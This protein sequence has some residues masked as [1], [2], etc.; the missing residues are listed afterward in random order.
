MHV[1][2]VQYCHGPGSPEMLGGPVTLGRESEGNRTALI[3]APRRGTRR[4]LNCARIGA[5]TTWNTSRAKLCAHRRACNRR[6][7][8]CTE[9]AERGGYV[10][11]ALEC[12]GGPSHIHIY[13][14]LPNGLRDQSCYDRMVRGCDE[15]AL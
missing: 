7:R 2:L 15:A 9:P 4:A 8:G 3:R 5:R 12:I 1:S 14:E 10:R 13:E 6:V 11:S